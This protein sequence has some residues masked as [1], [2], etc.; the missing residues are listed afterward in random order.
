MHILA[1]VGV[2]FVNSRQPLSSRKKEVFYLRMQAHGQQ[3][4]HAYLPFSNWGASEDEKKREKK[5]KK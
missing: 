1:G 2:L 3:P 5:K 4:P